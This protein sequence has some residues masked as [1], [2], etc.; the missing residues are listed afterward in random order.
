MYFENDLHNNN[1]HLGMSDISQ[2]IGIVVVFVFF[3]L[4]T[5]NMKVS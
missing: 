3:I 1:T 2:H 5:L 4:S